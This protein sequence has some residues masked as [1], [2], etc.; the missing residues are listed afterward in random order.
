MHVFFANTLSLDLSRKFSEIA[1]VIFDIGAKLKLVLRKLFKRKIGIKVQKKLIV[2]FTK[3]RKKLDVF[4]KMAILIECILGEV[5]RKKLAAAS[6]H[7]IPVSL[8]LDD[9]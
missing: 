9:S 6:S 3:I 5:F 7:P 1:S 8:R 4:A 2:R